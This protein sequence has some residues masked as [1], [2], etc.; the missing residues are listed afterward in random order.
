M[1]TL[2]APSN[3]SNRRAIRKSSIYIGY[4]KFGTRGECS[5]QQLWMRSAKRKLGKETDEDE[6]KRANMIRS[7]V[8]TK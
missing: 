7:E 8:G 3:Q 1:F 6:Q 2:R 4:R 5:P